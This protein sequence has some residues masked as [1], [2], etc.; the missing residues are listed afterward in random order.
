MATV[1]LLAVLLGVFRLVPGLGVLLAIV[2]VP[3]WIHTNITLGRRQSRQ[4]RITFGDRFTVFANSVGV[5]ISVL[6]MLVAV[7]VGGFAAFCGLIDVAG[8][9]GE[10]SGSAWMAA[11]VFLGAVAFVF[12]G[13]SATRSALRVRRKREEKSRNA[14]DN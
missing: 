13:F 1:T 4:Q 11:L 8:G 5:T 10:F 14:R 12:A 3:A 7:I 6:I 9:G 2:L